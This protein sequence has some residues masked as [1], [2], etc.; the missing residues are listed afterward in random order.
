MSLFSKLLRL[1][2]WPQKLT[3]TT[4]QFLPFWKTFHVKKGIKQQWIDFL[5]KKHCKIQQVFKTCWLEP[6]LFVECYKWIIYTFHTIVN[7]GFNTF[8][9]EIIS[10][11]TYKNRYP[12]L[13]NAL[14]KSITVNNNL[15]A[16][17]VFE[18][19]NV[20]IKKKQYKSYKNKFTSLLRN[21]E[22]AYYSNK[23]EINKS[24][25]SKSWKVIREITGMNTIKPTHYSFSINDCIVTD[26]QKIT[27]E[28][29]NFFVNIGPHFLHT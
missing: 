1:E 2:Y 18:P 26:K 25:N 28:F 12:R 7:N 11:V 17:L 23:L 13:T 5:S 29:N 3:L 16:L 8:F 10:T 9:P 21:A 6:C 15:S 24:D 27:N 20:S 22:L 4:F 14:R 19:E